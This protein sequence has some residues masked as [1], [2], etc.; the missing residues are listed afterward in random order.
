MS[1]LDR[2][3][4]PEWMDTDAEASTYDAMDHGAVNEAFAALVRG[5]L[6]SGGRVV[7]LG[8]GTALIPLRVVDGCPTLRIVAVD[9]AHHMLARARAH[10]AQL[11]DADGRVL[12]VR[13][14]GK[15]LPFADGAF[16]GV[17]S[18]S[19]VHHIPEPASV[20]AEMARLVRFGGAVVVRD[21][22]RPT[23]MAELERL[24][25]TY[26]GDETPLGQKLFHDSLHAALTLDEVRTMVDA[27]GLAGCDVAQTSDRH[28]TVYRAVR[29]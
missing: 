2:I 17:I 25:A 26:A 3:L 4:E 12:L 14:D 9:A 27:A 29:P 22:L 20:F 28:W 5:A 7:D 16:D 23:D 11:G 15:G 21:L 10:V 13:A 24:V 19:I 18:N 1:R 8:T 6:P